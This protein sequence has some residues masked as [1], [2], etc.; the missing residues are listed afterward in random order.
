MTAFPVY[1]YGGEPN[2]PVL[3]LALANGFPPQTYVPLLQPFSASYR[4]LSFLPRPLWENPP[5]PASLVSWQGMADD[6]LAALDAHGI[7]EPI[8][9][10]GHSMGGVATMLA[11]LQ[12][13]ERFRGIVLLDPTIF[14]PRY[15]WLMA[16][17][18][19]VGLN[20]RFPLVNK[21]LKR[22]AQFASPEEAFTYWRGKALFTDWLDDTLRLYVE[23]LLTPAAGGGYRL[24][25]SPAWEARYYAT[26]YTQTWSKIGQLNG[27]MPVL[28][29]RGDQTN[30]FLAPAPQL[31]RQ[32]LPK[33]TFAEIG[34]HG[35]L[36]PQSAPDQTRELMQNWLSTLPPL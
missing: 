4:V 12:S 33:M 1:H 30:T 18:R 25:W 3:H 16:V 34:G 24:R 31:M 5:P 32:R 19:A 17:M 9:G 21:A 14:P 20:A 36:F 27:L 26:I 29:I 13:P 23:G 7:R 10:V 11:A 6:L 15:L 28:T 8:V 35:H 2:K 22:R